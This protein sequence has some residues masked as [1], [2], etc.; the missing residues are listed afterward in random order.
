MS[1]LAARWKHLDE[2]F[3]LRKWSNDNLRLQLGFQING[4]KTLRY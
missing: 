4:I 1:L 3:K 2:V